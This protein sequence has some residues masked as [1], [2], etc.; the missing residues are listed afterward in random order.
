M[1]TP[2][3]AV[4]RLSW[5]G[6]RAR[7][8]DR[9]ALSVPVD[10]AATGPADVVAAMC[11]AHAQVMSAAELSIGLRLAGATRTDVRR[12]LWEERALVKTHGPRGTVHLLPARDLPMWT[13][14]LAA[15]PAT[16]MQAKAIRLDPGQIEEVVAAIAAAVADAELTIDELD[17]A[18]TAATGP[19]AADPVMPAFQ[20]MWPRWRQ[21]LHTAA[22]RGALCFGPDRGRKVTYT[23]PRRWLPG[24]RPMEARAAVTEVVRRYLYAYGPATP[25]HF[26]RWLA[27]PP[28]WAAELFASMAGELQ[29]VEVE[30]AAAWVLAGDTEVPDEPARSVRLLPYFDAF[31]I[32]CQPRDLVFPGRAAERALARGQAGNYPLLLI[33]GTVAGVWHQRRSGRWID[34]TVEPLDALDTRQARGLD[35]QIQRVGA[36]MEAAPRVRIG[37][38]TVGPHA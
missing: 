21:A 27:A 9:N 15:V 29:Q 33:D 4:Q 32:A 6:V 35:E 3:P 26:A 25:R 22:L 5:A 10:T 23:S 24:F 20:G 38:V 13:G 30:G 34:I 19:W 37:A 18:V 7:R 16:S 17:A 14:A 1:T 12:G 36:I 8:L 11:G 31:G 28:G 2:A